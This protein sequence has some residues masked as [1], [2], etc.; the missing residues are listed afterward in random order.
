MIDFPIDE[1]LD[2]AACQ[3]WLEQQLHPDGLQ[4]PKCCAAARRV[5]RRAGEFAG[6][7]CRSCDCYYTVLSG[8]SFAK[9]HQ[10]PAKLVL[11]LRGIAK[12]ESTARLAR[13]LQVSRKQVH[14]LRQ[15]VQHNVY[16]QQPHAVLGGKVFEVDELYQNAGGKKHAS[17]PAG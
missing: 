15:R 1:L 3:Q 9:T 4:C 6:Y 8:T 2:S 13:E 7:R 12:G 14:V 17:L 16:E 10:T 5:A 11:L